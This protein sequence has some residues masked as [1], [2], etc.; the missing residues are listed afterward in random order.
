[1]ARSI[2]GVMNR[3]HE[4]LR[5]AWL[6]STCHGSG[7]LAQVAI[8][9]QKT[10]SCNRRG[11]GDKICGREWEGIGDS[12]ICEGEDVRRFDTAKDHTRKLGKVV[13]GFGARQQALKDT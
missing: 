10:Q 12:R 1:M 3:W 8:S 6:T 7:G 13:K 2:D 4:S 5:Q 11:I 9:G